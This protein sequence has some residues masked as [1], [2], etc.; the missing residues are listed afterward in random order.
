MSLL[1]DQFVINFRNR[2]LPD[3]HLRFWNQW[4]EAPGSGAPCHGGSA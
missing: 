2:I 1:A 3:Q 4:T